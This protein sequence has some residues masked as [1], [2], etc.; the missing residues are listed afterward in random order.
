MTS[1]R[2]SS[3]KESRM[4]TSSEGSRKEIYNDPEPSNNPSSSRSKLPF[5]Y[6]NSTREHAD[7]QS[8]HE[9]SKSTSSSKDVNIQISIKSDA[10]SAA[11]SD[12]E[13]I[14]SRNESHV[15]IEQTSLSSPKESVHDEGSRCLSKEYRPPM[16]IEHDT[17]SGKSNIQVQVDMSES[18][19]SQHDNESDKQ[20]F[21]G[22]ESLG[23]SEQEKFPIEN[24]EFDDSSK[25]IGSIQSKDRSSIKNSSKEIEVIH[26]SEPS[27]RSL[28][29]AQMTGT[30]NDSKKEIIIEE[31]SSD[32][33]KQ[34]LIGDD[35][36]TVS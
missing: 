36:N 13:E 8:H 25:D 3:R 27:R 17:S 19:Q 28:S 1:D 22:H 32:S 7:D 18:H 29:N 16:S 23:T 10:N 30:D 34:E 4:T 35:L 20:S 33:S 5:S 2:D 14:L 11:D 31:L 9:I 21:Y 6:S 24:D 15:I 26:E 12:K